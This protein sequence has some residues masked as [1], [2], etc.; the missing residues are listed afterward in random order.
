M[1]GNSIKSRVIT[2]I[3]ELIKDEN[4]EDEKEKSSFKFPLINNEEKTIHNQLNL[5]NSMTV[6]TVKEKFTQNNFFDII[7][8]DK[9]GSIII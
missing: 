4:C 8:F 5:S 6:M 7:D 2:K 1:S 9:I 3:K